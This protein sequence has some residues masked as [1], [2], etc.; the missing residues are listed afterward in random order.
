MSRVTYTVVVLVSLLVGCG[1]NQQPAAEPPASTASTASSPSPSPTVTTPALGPIAK[2]CGPPDVP[3]RQLQLDGPDGTQLSAV[4][5]GSGPVG[6]VFL[7][8]TG[9]L[10]LCGFWPYAVWLE[11]EYGLR[12]LLLDLCGYGDSHCGGGP[13]SNDLVAQTGVA[14]QWLRA[15]GGQRITLVGASMGGTVAAVASARLEPRVD[16]VVDLSGPLVWEGLDV[17]AAAPD[18]RSPALFAVASYDIVVSVQ[19]LRS[20]LQRTNGP[21]RFVV[22]PAGHGWQLLG[23]RVGADYTVDPIGRQVAQWIEHGRVTGS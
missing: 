23:S 7:H 14:V 3:A 1:E 12:S 2:R 15:H 5:V 6:A 9:E 11:R 8:E 16:A 19:E 22:A 21:Q 13:F 10:G 4:E 17:A 20:V 18:I